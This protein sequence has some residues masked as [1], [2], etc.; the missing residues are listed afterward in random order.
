VRGATSSR[1]T[2]SRACMSSTAASASTEVFL[3]EECGR[4]DRSLSPASHSAATRRIHV[5]T[6]F[7]E[8][9]VTAAIGARFQPC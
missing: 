7:R 6:H 4:D 1:P 2:R 8:T 5:C 9:P 3:G